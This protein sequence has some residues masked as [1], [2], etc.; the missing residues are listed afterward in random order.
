MSR[1]TSSTGN[2]PK[3]GASPGSSQA[4]RLLLPITATRLI[5]FLWIVFAQSSFVVRGAVPEKWSI[6]GE[7]GDFVYFNAPRPA[8]SDPSLQLTPEEQVKAVIDRERN[9][10]FF[11][12]EVLA[13]REIGQFVELDGI[14][15][16]LSQVAMGF[17]ANFSEKAGAIVT[18]YSPGELDGNGVRK[19]GRKL[20]E[21]PMDIKAGYGWAS[22]TFPQNLAT[23]LP[24]RVFITLRLAG[25]Q[26]G[27]RLSWTAV[28]G[29]PVKGKTASSLYW[30]RSGPDEG[31]WALMPIRNLRGDDGNLVLLVRQADPPNPSS[32]ALSLPTIASSIR[33]APVPEPGPF[34]LGVVGIAILAFL[35]RP[36]AKA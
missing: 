12:S 14:R 31:D 5:A 24:G 32:P 11:D 25:N 8:P 6:K 2:T 18:I 21:R 27:R 7:L 22:T 19:P 34:A 13:D 28:L 10:L 29:S 23:R 33:V 1:M 16:S 26:P 20:L 17:K 4:K 30:Q 36:R 3:D 9:P 15:T 35:S